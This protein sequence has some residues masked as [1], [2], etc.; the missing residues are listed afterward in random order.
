MH[1]A[2]PRSDATHL[3][4]GGCRPP[5]KKTVALPV[6][7]PAVMRP[8]A[9]PASLC[10][11]VYRGPDLDALRHNPGFDI[12][13]QRDQQLPR[14]CHDGDPP[15]ASLQHADALTEPCGERTARL[16]AQP[17]PGE[18]DERRAGP[19]VARSADA[20]VAIH[21]AALVGHGCDAD[22]AGELTAVGE[23]AVE[24]L[25]HQHRGEVRADATQALE[26][27]DLLGHLIVG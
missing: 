12:A 26:G 20:S 19:R 11:G 8:A 7:P 2:L 16:V 14:H 13:P 10:R 18:L 27:S 21:A 1:E 25:A 3:K 23:G 9:I 5:K 24:H 22:V 6:S 17:K 4:R 15:R